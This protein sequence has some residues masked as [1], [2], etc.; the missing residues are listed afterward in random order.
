MNIYQLT[1]LEKDEIY[2]AEINDLANRHDGVYN[3]Y[4][5]KDGL[6]YFIK[7]PSFK[8]LENFRLTIKKFYLFQKTEI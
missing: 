3:T 8:N 7:F 6:V 4:R 5:T 2:I 1:L